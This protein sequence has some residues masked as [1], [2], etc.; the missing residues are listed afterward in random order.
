[1][2]HIENIF[3]KIILS[4]EGYFYFIFGLLVIIGMSCKTPDQFNMHKLLMVCSILFQGF[5]YS[6]R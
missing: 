3:N 2:F 5:K 4:I 6:D 1:M